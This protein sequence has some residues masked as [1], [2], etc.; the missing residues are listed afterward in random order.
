M[1]QIPAEGGFC[2]ETGS[3]AVYLFRGEAIFEFYLPAQLL[4]MQVE[5][6]KFGVWSDVG[7]VNPPQ[8]AIYNW[9]SETWLNLDGLVTGENLIP[10]ADGLLSETGTLRIRMTGDQTSQGCFY[11]GMGVDGLP[12]AK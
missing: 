8:T 11:L 2:G 5:Q 6:L 7:I 9:Q 12:A 1:V 4:D 10:A 3:T